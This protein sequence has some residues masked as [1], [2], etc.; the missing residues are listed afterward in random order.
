MRAALRALTVVAPSALLVW[1]WAGCASRSSLHSLKAD[2]S[3]DTPVAAMT[4][5]FMLGTR[6]GPAV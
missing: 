3:E 6:G 5:T 2:A 1:A 4:A